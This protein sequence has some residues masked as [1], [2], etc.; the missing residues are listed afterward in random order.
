MSQIKFKKQCTAVGRNGLSN[1]VGVDIFPTSRLDE[2][3]I[4]FDIISIQP[5][6]S[7]GFITNC[8]IELEM[9]KIPDIIKDLQY[10]YDHHTKT[11]GIQ[12][13]SSNQSV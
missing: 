1:C 10:F 4:P 2:Q 6:N 9:D 11:K 5:I 13:P 8:W 3:N 12:R 7:K